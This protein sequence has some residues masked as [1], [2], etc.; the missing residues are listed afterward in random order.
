M[1]LHYLGLDHIGHI[2][3]PSS[4]LVG[5][6]LLEMD[7]VVNDIYKAML[8]W[9]RKRKG[10][11]PVFVLCGDHGMSDAGSHGGASSAETNTPLVFMSP[12]FEHSGGEEFSK[13]QVQQIDL[14]PT[15]S[16]LSGTSYSS[17]QVK[18]KQT[19]SEFPD[20]LLKCLTPVI[21]HSVLEG[22]HCPPPPPPPRK[23]EQK[24]GMPE[25]IYQTK[26]TLFHHSSKHDL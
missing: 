17:K 22:G 12:L 13:K 25:V 23:R 16:L 19:G 3:G 7:S 8:K 18:H 11:F 10:P 2:A 21:R 24:N 26:Q 14:V 9:N 15:L 5:P 20:V 4:P 1:I 6:K